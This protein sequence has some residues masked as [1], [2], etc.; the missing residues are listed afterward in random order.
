[1]IS[2]NASKGCQD[3][4]SYTTI[5]VGQMLVAE[6][7]KRVSQLPRTSTD[8]RLVFEHL[9]DEALTV[10]EFLERIG[11]NDAENKL[12]YRPRFSDLVTEGTVYVKKKVCFVCGRKEASYEVV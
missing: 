4:R 10:C 11:K 5:D 7:H 9:R 3:L 8:R 2:Y 6:N 1:M 12:R